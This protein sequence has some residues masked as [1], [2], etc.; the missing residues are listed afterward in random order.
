MIRAVIWS[1][2]SLTA[3][4]DGEKTIELLR[5]RHVHSVLIAEFGSAALT[6]YR[7]GSWYVNLFRSRK[8]GDGSDRRL[9]NVITFLWKKD[10]IKRDQMVYVCDDAHGVTVAKRNNIRA[11]V[12]RTGEFSLVREELYR[13]I[14]TP[15]VARERI[16]PSAQFVPGLVKRLNEA[17]MELE[18]EIDDWDGGDTAA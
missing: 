11:I 15:L 9:S 2:G 17:E 4:P 3:V 7:S 16:V 5:Q 14:L 1:E 13:P 6:A 12:V 10:D 18:A 8:P